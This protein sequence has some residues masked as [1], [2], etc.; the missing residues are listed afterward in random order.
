MVPDSI[1]SVFDEYELEV[2]SMMFQPF[3]VFMFVV[4]FR[5]A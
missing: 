2:S 3:F 4:F 1:L 5:S